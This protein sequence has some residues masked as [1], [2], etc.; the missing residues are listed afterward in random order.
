[1]LTDGNYTEADPVPAAT[2]AAGQEIVIHTI[3]FSAGA[4][5][6][7]MQSVASEGGGNHHHADNAGDLT[8]IFQEIAASLTV[9]ID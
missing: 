8:A 2:T 9:L 3:T 7:T 5:Q 6:T 4:D 1:V